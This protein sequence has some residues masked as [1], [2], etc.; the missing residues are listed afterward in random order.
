M[1]PKIDIEET[2]K[3]LV[4][5]YGGVV[6]EDKLPKS[7]DF[8]NADYV[9]HFEKI[10][11]E[12][13]CLT[14]DNIYSVENQTK[15]NDLLQKWFNEGNIQTNKIDEHT[16]SRLPRELQT[17]IC[18][19]TTK[20]IRRRIQTA[21]AQIRETKRA[22]HLDDYLG[23]A[24]L[25]NDGISSLPPAA[26]IHAAYLALAHDFS[27]IKYFIYLTTNLFT[28]LRGVP[29][30]VVFWIGFDMQK[31]P[32][33]DGKFIDRLGANWRRLVSRKT[34]I[35]G[36]EQELNDMEGFWHAKHVPLKPL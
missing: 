25:A 7:P 32:K 21:N 1:Y 29:M 23:L 28:Q 12:L 4:R 27:E 18:E 16:W 26:F 20:S 36:I 31:G 15:V 19:I 5:D 30:P 22:L 10:V 9:F 35:P 17:R 24:V 6:L 2:F 13:K 33:M 3:E 11:A 8:K 34:G 14:V